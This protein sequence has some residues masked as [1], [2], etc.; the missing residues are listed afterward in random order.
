[1]LLMVKYIEK[2]KVQYQTPIH[3]LESVKNY[4]YMYTFTL[5]LPQNSNDYM[6]SGHI[7]T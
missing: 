1:M 2:L 7:H 3:F 6:C 5:K 4:V